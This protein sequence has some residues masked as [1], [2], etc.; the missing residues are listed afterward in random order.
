MLVRKPYHSH[1]T[2]NC[3]RPAGTCI[4][5]MGCPTGRGSLKCLKKASISHK[6]KADLE[7]PLRIAKC[8]QQGC[9]KV[10]NQMLKQS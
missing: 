3:T 5:R 8:E 7:P 6:R 10:G 9:A 4:Q 1:N 2:E